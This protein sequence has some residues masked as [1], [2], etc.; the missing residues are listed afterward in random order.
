MIQYMSIPFYIFGSLEPFKNVMKDTDILPRKST[1][2]HNFRVSPFIILF[3]VS[4]LIPLSYLQSLVGVL[5]K[6]SWHPASPPF[7]S[8]SPHPPPSHTA[9]TFS[10]L[11]FTLL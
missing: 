8:V 1:R 7:L 3:D 9:G 2:V 6:S 4:H 11:L 5:Q 10:G